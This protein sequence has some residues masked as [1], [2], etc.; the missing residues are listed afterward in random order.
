MVIFQHGPF[1][2]VEI[3]SFE[4][5]IADLWQSSDNVG[6]G[7]LLLIPGDGSVF[8]WLNNFT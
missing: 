2:N 7:I 5:P 4:L 3:C 1:Q 8:A 6:S